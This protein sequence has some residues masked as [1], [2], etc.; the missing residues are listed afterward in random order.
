MP[1]CGVYVDGL[2]SLVIS[3]ACEN[4]ILLLEA[5]ESDTSYSIC[6]KTNVSCFELNLTTCYCELVPIRFGGI[7]ES[8]LQCKKG[9]IASTNPKPVL[10]QSLQS[11]D[12]GRPWRFQ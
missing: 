6:T 11:Y 9:Y 10:N 4:E 2:S 3:N 12:H 8:R 1:Q 5:M 7:H